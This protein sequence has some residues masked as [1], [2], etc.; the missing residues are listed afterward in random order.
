MRILIVTQYFWPESFK[1]NDIALG[2]KELG[3]EVF[4]LTALPNYPHGKLYEGY[5]QKS[6]DEYWNGIKIYRSRIIPR[7][8]SG[9]KLFLNYISFVWYGLLKV[10]K[11]K[12]SVDRIL[13]YEPSPITVGLPAIRASKKLEAPCYFWVQDLWPQSLTAAGGI[14][15]PL[16]LRCFDLITKFIYKKSQK[17]LVQSK[18]FQYYI[19]NQG[20]PS[21]KI[22]FYPNSTE[23]FYS[24]KQPLT[25]IDEMLPLGFRIMFAGNLGESQSLNTL[26]DAAKIVKQSNSEIKWIFLGD[27]RAKESIINNI[28]N[29]GLNDTVFLLGSFPAIKMPDF[30]ATSDVLIASLK[31]DPIF[32]LT[33]PSKIQSYLACGKPILASLDG[34]GAKIIEESKC[35]YASNAE[36]S[37]SL[38][39]NVLK[40]Y[41]LSQSERETMGENA[42]QY[43][44]EHFERNMLLK[45]LVNILET[46]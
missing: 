40:M 37:V 4:V 30:F 45:K 33:I 24:K 16:I 42:I 26:I 31:S 13:V 11:I 23:E 14:T 17:I 21:D 7:G 38:A 22:I 27:G 39:K 9:L 28:N 34:E 44:N 18:G 29:E 46:K 36:D 5:T 41:N 6:G 43:F 10:S 3:H 25:N 15:N 35:G 32:A 12:E 8:T 20:V 1:I 19:E 2:L